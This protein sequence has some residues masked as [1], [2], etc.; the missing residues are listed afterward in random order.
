MAF[1]MNQHSTGRFI[2]PQKK[3]SIISNV[4]WHSAS[5]LKRVHKFGLE[6]P[7]MVEEAVA[8]N[9]K[10]RNTLW[11]DAVQK[12]M[13]LVEVTFQTIHEGEKLQRV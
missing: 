10:K 2:I 1:N 12:K 3:D 6:L 5:Y 7:K 13:E 9:K 11:Q 8:I 4:K